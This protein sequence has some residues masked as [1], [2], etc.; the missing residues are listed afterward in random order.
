M[1]RG[2]DEYTICKL[3]AYIE[4][5]IQG[6]KPE[7]ERNYTEFEGYYRR[8]QTLCTDNEDFE[9]QRLDDAYQQM[10]KEGFLNG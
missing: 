8:A 3:L 5:D 4:T 7:R 9:M 10:K 2:G 6:K 1:D